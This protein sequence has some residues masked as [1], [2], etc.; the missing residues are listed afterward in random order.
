[1]HCTG[2]PVQVVW[3]VEGG[4]GGV[5]DTDGIII[6]VI[7]IIIIIFIIIIIVVIIIIIICHYLLIQDKTLSISVCAEVGADT[8]ETRSN[9]SNSI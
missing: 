1:M 5:E 4:R 2:V 7:I 3:G 9:M 6:I 8:W